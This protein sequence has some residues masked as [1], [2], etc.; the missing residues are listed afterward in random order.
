MSLINENEEFYSS[1]PSKVIFINKS[2]NE[3]NKMNIYA[4]VNNCKEKNN[5]YEIK[6]FEQNLKEDNSKQIKI[7]KKIKFFKKLKLFNK[8]NYIYQYNPKLLVIN[9]NMSIFVFCRF[10]DKSFCLINSKGEKKYYLTESIV[11]CLSKSSEKSFFTGHINGKIIEWKFSLKNV[12]N[13]LIGE[14]NIKKHNI[15]IFIEELEVKRKYMAHTEKIRGIYYSY[16]LGLIITNGDDNKI[17][18]RKYYD[19]TLLTMIDL[20]LNKICVDIKISHCFLYILFYDESV[21]KHI[22]QIYSVNGIKVGEGNYN[23]INSINFDNFGNVLIGC[24]NENK[25]E[26]Y[27]PAMTKKINDIHINI[28]NYKKPVV[29]EKSKKKKISKKM[30]IEKNSNDNIININNVLFNDFI[31]DKESN[32]LYCSFSNGMIV[33]KR[34]T[35]INEST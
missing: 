16:L 3:S 9:F 1:F 25:I 30:S 12:N 31:Y 6:I 13:I 5:S 26:V 14:E 17:M 10:N 19:L 35:Y 11:T 27:N 2:K 29:E 34:Y 8:D 33:K 24:Y 22:V 7:Q 15:N 18:I 21:K 20:S 4:L 28:Q 23:Y 32:S